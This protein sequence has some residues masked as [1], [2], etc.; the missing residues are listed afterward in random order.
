MILSEVSDEVSGTV[1]IVYIPVVIVNVLYYGNEKILHIIM[2]CNSENFQ[3]I[4]SL[5]HASLHTAD[6]V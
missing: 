2:R 5:S 1:P 6:A 3:H 4:I